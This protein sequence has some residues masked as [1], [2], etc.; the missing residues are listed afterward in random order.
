MAKAKVTTAEAKARTA[1]AKALAKA[2]EKA[3]GVKPPLREPSVLAK[4]M[5]GC[6]QRLQGCVG[7][8]VQYHGT[9]ISYAAGREARGVRF[10]TVGQPRELR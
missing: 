4:R 7:E 2:R 9:R 1:R 6:G 10:G 3:R 8:V 5:S